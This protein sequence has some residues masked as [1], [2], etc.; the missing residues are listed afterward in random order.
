MDRDEI[1]ELI[2]TAYNGAFLNEMQVAESRLASGFHRRRGEKDQGRCL[3][4]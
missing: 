1:R 4:G 2:L 3:W